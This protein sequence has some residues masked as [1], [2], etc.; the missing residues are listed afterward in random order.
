MSQNYIADKVISYEIEEAA[1]GWTEAEK[2]VLKATKGGQKH[3][4]VSVKTSKKRKPTETAA[5][6]Y[7]QEMGEKVH[8]KAKKP[9]K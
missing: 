8:K 3:P 4:M 1:P 7:E 2:Q 9:S 6:I 5:Q